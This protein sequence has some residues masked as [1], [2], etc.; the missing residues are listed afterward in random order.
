MCATY[1]VSRITK[2]WPCVI[3]YSLMNISKTNAE[4]LYEFSKLNDAPKRRRICVKNLPMS[5]MKEH[6]ISRSHIKTLPMDV[7]VF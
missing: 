1:T 7:S 4:V 3:F 6:L 2:C 5:L